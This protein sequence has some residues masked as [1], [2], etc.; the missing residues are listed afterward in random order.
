MPVLLS[1]ETFMLIV[2]AVLLGALFMKV[3][4][5]KPPSENSANDTDEF[6]YASKTVSKTGVALSTA[7][8]YSAFATV[9]FWFLA[10]GY[11]YGLWLLVIPAALLIGN[12]IFIRFVRAFDF[13]FSSYLTISQL[14]KERSG[15]SLLTL[16]TDFIV[17][18]FL[19]SALL[20]EIVIGSSLVHA[21]IGGVPGG[22][23]T[24]LIGLLVLVLAYVLLGGYR[25]IVKTDIAQVLFMTAGIIALIA[26]AVLYGQIDGR[27]D[28]SP[29][30]FFLPAE[31]HNVWSIAALFISAFSI[32]I[33]GP[34][35]QLT[36]WQRIKAAQ[37][38]EKQETGI[39]GHMRGIVFTSVLWALIAITGIMLHGFF[40]SDNPLNDVLLKMKETD[41][42]TAYV[43]SPLVGVSLVFALVSTADSLIG[44]LFLSAYDIAKRRNAAFSLTNAYKYGLSSAV[45]VI[46]MLFYAINQSNIAQVAITIIYFLFAQLVVIFP[47]VIYMISGKSRGAEPIPV[48]R[49][50]L[51][52]VCG[53]CAVLALTITGHQTGIVEFIFIASGAGVLTSGAI[54]LAGT[55][56]YGG[57]K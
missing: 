28:N 41:L 18:I 37:P 31:R 20:V 17:I 49:L 55:T 25:A 53:W 50:A 54:I 27:A 1:P 48:L 33:F 16:L 11:D 36:N 34:V 46:I 45:F 38:G 2:L 21:L 12:L 29:D 19:M 24:I 23:L 8:T 56:K 7:A 52:T 14:I 22:Q 35:C 39:Q 51:G 3:G 43:L 5:S 30:H 6:L 26:F 57:V 13:D 15:S 40:H 47:M 32:H 9:V 42:F 44:A 4:L 10:L